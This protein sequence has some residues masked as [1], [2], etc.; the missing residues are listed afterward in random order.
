[1]TYDRYYEGCGHTISDQQPLRKASICPVCK[2]LA[3]APT[4]KGRLQADQPEEELLGQMRLSGIPKPSRNYQITSSRKFTFDFAWPD[5]M[6][7]VEVE[8]GTRMKGGGRHNRHAGYQRD[9]EKYSLAAE[10]GWKVHRFTSDD[11]YKGRA[12]RRIEQLFGVVS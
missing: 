5:K 12:I 8:G 6:M 4:R 2:K 11:V 7:A 1:M 3:Q 9:C 10:L